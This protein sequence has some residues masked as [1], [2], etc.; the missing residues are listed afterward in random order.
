MK[1]NLLAATAAL[2][3]SF[4]IFAPAAR[5]EGVKLTVEKVQHQRDAARSA[6]DRLQ[7]HSDR[8]CVAYCARMK[9]DIGVV[10]QGL[11][12]FSNQVKNGKLDG[13]SAQVELERA[14]HQFEAVRSAL[15]RL[16]MV[17]SKQEAR[18]RRVEIDVGIVSA[19]VQNLENQTRNA[20]RDLK[21]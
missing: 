1:T 3:A 5:A 6:Q 16:A 9:V 17:A 7:L 2:I 12:N 19:V 11:I 14:V 4:G 21:A 15:S 8:F 10:E 13:A 20:L 18:A